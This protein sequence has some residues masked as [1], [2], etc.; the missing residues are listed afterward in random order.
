[1]PNKSK[2][3]PHIPA[4]FE[5]ALGAILTVKPPKGKKRSKPPCAVCGKAD[6]NW[7]HL[8]KKNPADKSWHKYRAS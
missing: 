3:V 6:K 4:K 5:D 2:P 7:V 1:M 8:P